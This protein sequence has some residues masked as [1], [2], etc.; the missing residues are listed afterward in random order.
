MKLQVAIS[1]FMGQA[2]VLLCVID[3]DTGVLTIGKQAP[4]TEERKEGFALV[5]N[6]DL[7]DYDFEFT[8]KHLSDAIRSYFSRAGQDM[9]AFAPSLTRYQPD[10]RIEKDTVDESGPRYRISPDIDN[11]QIAVLA[12]VAFATK[13]KPISAAAEMMNELSQLYAITTI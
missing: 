11:G 9:V 2:T 3:D 5:T 6:L 8:D 4:F 7:P 13:Q 12:A 10:N 1:G